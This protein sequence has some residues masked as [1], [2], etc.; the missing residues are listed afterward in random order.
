M[1]AVP[2]SLRHRMSAL[3]SPLK[4]FL[5]WIFQVLSTCRLMLPSVNTVA[6]SIRKMLVVPLTCRHRMSLKASALKSPALTALS[7]VRVMSL[8]SPPW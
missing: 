1:L 4:S 5:S 6:P 2:L 7:T 3:P 8:P